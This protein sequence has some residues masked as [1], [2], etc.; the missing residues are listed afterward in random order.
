MSLHRKTN[1]YH[2]YGSSLLIASS[3]LLERKVYVVT[4]SR[5]NKKLVFY[6]WIIQQNLLKHPTYLL[7]YPNLSLTI[8][9]QT[10]TACFL[11]VYTWKCLLV[12]SNT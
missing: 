12:L 11:Y 3:E 7:T 4:R 1:K 5:L 9:V 6:H 8:F 10:I 2:V